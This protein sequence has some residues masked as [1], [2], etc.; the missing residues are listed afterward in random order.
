[1]Q[2]GQVTGLHVFPGVSWRTEWL[3]FLMFS[4]SKQ[5]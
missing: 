1:M 5:A 4:N 2:A 3:V